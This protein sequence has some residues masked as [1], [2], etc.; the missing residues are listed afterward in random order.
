MAIP[1]DFKAWPPEESIAFDEDEFQFAFAY[2]TEVAHAPATMLNNPRNVKFKIKKGRKTERLVMKDNPMNRLGL[3]MVQRFQN[4]QR[5]YFSFMFRWFA[6]LDLIKSDVLDGR[7]RKKAQK[8]G[9]PEEIH[10][11]IV[12][13]AGSFPLTTS[14][15]FD[16]P[17]FLAELKQ[18]MSQYYDPAA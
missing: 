3:A 7:L 12:R 15:K 13:L 17:A 8:E 5:K 4:D 16:Q 1:K 6:F 2:A 18:R 10:T 11:E 9:E 14:G